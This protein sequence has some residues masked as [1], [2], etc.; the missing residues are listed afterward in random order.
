MLDPDAP[1]GT[2][3]LWLACGIPPSAFSL[4]AVPAGAAEGIN[5]FG[6]RG[7]G[8]RARRGA[9]CIITTSWSWRWMPS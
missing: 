7:Y 8:A 5:D 9:L 1:G 3:T 2:F 4:A 6:R